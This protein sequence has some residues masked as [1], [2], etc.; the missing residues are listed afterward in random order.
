MLGQVASLVTPDTLPAWQRALIA[1]KYYGS[2]RRGPGR[3]PVM[4][5]IRSLVGRMA[6]ENRD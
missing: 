6:K 1:R 3:P 2:E 4:E 5:Q